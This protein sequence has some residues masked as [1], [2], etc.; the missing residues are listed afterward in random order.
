MNMLIIMIVTIFHIRLMKL[1]NKKIPIKVF[2]ITI[3]NH[4]L[5]QNHNSIC[6][7]VRRKA[8]NYRLLKWMNLSSCLR[9]IV[10]DRFH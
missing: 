2:I 7:Q 5:N 6:C 10:T 3:K 4:K 8:G 9:Q 1:M